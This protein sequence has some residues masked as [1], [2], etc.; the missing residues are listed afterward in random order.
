[1]YR[2]SKK[3]WPKTKMAPAGI[4][5][6]SP[7]SRGLM[8]KYTDRIAGTTSFDV[9]SLGQTSWEY[10]AAI[11]KPGVRHAAYSPGG[12]RLVVAGVPDISVYSAGGV[13]QF[14]LNLAQPV[15]ADINAAPQADSCHIDWSADGHRVY[16]CVQWEDMLVFRIFS[17]GSDAHGQVYEF[18]VAHPGNPF[19]S[20]VVSHCHVSSKVLVHW[21]KTSEHSVCHVQ[22]LNICDAGLEPQSSLLCCHSTAAFSPGGDFFAVMIDE[23]GPASVADSQRKLMLAVYSSDSARLVRE[24]RHPDWVQHQGDKLDVTDF[25]RK[26]RVIWGPSMRYIFVLCYVKETLPG[27]GSNE[28]AQRSYAEHLVRMWFD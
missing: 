14:Q 15:S 17:A 21:L 18:S 13:L 25:I 7:T 8:V 5:T 3:V 9:Y 26:Y 11:T 4:P 2:W 24:V 1:M 23:P 6:F 27:N 28:W 12:D 16:H 20:N 19:A 22:L 10:A